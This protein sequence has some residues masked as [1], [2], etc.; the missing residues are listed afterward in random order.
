[1]FHSNNPFIN[2]SDSGNRAHVVG[3][4]P[5]RSLRDSFKLTKLVIGNIWKNKVLPRQIEGLTSAGKNGNNPPFG[6]EATQ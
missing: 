3:I 6:M 5:T 2:I 1:M 4:G